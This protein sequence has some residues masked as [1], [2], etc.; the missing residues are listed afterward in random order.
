MRKAIRILSIA[1]LAVTLGYVIFK[2]GLIYWIVQTG[3]GSVG[4]ISGADGL[5]A[6]FVTRRPAS[7]ARM[8]LPALGIALPIVGIVLTRKK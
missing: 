8:L 6:I 4:I 7:T 2:L 1:V 5:T 3:S